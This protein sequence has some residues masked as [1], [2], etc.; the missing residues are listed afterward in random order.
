MVALMP[1][2]T[3]A[4]IAQW[5]D[6]IGREAVARERL[7]PSAL[8]RYAHAVGA[9]DGA[10]VPLPHW[11]FFLSSVADGDIGPDGHP[12]RGGFLPAISLPRRMFAAASIVF[13][14]PLEIGMD[15]HMHQTIAAVMH[16]AGRSG[17]LLFVEIDHVLTQRDRAR[18][19]ERRTY[20]YR[21]LTDPAAMPDPIDPAPSG[22]L[23]QPDPVN[24]FRFSAATFNSHRIHYDRPY[25][26][27]VEGYPALV[28]H[29][30]F[31]A[32][33]L[34]ALAMRE[35]PLATFDFRASAPLFLGQPIY[36]RR[37]DGNRVQ[38]QRCDGVEAMVAT[39]SHA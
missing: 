11:A 36:L 33:R 16:K 22:E 10:S 28:V 39:V 7:D 21:G 34:A 26:T 3:P 6:A 20:V 23:W 9:A 38:A 30:P 4:Q 35:G 14:C 12:C 31:T 1:E 5:Q 25:A 19:R 37:I 27:G 17:D 18:V 13:E 2:V 24:L 15:A 32:A 8:A 29:G